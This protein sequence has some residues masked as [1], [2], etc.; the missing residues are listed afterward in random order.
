MDEIRRQD[1]VRMSDGSYT[2]AWEFDHGDTTYYL[3]ELSADEFSVL[4]EVGQPSAVGYTPVL[5]NERQEIVRAF[6]ADGGKH[7][8]DDIDDEHTAGLKLALHYWEG[9]SDG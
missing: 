8:S 5:G 3:Q 4:R 1:D 9:A 2:L 7:V 6:L